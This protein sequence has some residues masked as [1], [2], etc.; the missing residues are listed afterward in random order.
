MSPQ[1]VLELTTKAI[2]A[3]GGFF[4]GFG[5][6]KW[7]EERKRK[8]RSPEYPMS[9]YPLRLAGAGVALFLMG[10]TIA[11]YAGQAAR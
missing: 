7:Y 6:S 5:I 1:D 9:D 3:F 11:V 4:I 2:M 10:V 8:K